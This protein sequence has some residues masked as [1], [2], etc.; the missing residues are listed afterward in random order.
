MDPG[1]QPKKSEEHQR[2]ESHYCKLIYGR[3]YKVYKVMKALRGERKLGFCK[4]VLNI[5]NNLRVYLCSSVPPSLLEEDNYYVVCDLDEVLIWDKMKQN[6]TS[7]LK[8]SKSAGELP[9]Y[10]EDEE[11]K[12]IDTRKISCCYF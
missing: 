1:V 12:L 11:F 8:K 2:L 3:H 10:K 9:D 5:L 4:R 7:A 6:D